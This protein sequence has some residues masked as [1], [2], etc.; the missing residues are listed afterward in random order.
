MPKKKIWASFQRILELCTQ[1]F[2]NKLSKIRVWDPRSRI[3][4]KGTG[5]RIRI[6]NNAVKLRRTLILQNIASLNT[7]YRSPI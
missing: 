4:K 7:K 6:H 3:R 1:K 5:S 2:V